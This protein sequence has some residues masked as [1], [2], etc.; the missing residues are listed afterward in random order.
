[1]SKIARFTPSLKT[2]SLKCVL[3]VTQTASKFHAS[4]YLDAAEA[5]APVAKTKFFM[6]F[7]IIQYVQ[8]YIGFSITFHYELIEF[9]P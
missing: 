4:A 1:M 9:M 2:L 5:A 7:I 8:I 3:P 6:A